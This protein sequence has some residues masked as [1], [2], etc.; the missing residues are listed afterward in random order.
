M[1][2]FGFAMAITAP[3]KTMGLFWIRFLNVGAILIPL[4]F[5]HF[6]FSLLKIYWQ[7]KSSCISTIYNQLFHP[8]HLELHPLVHKRCH[9]Q[10]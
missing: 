5:L 10:K 4:F 1:W 8:S 9:H 7:K 2:A 3:D 6:V